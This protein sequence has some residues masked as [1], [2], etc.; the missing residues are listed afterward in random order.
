MHSVNYHLGVGYEV[1]KGPDAWLWLVVSAYRNAGAIGVAASQGQ[2]ARDACL[3]IEEMTAWPCPFAAASAWACGSALQSSE[4]MTHAKIQW[5]ATLGQL[6][7]YL[8]CV[9]DPLPGS[10]SASSPCV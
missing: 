2:A 5:E 10:S 9:A 3:A 7:H 4:A 6:Q 1:W 8:S